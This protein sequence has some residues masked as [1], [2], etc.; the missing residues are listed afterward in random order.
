MLIIASEHRALEIRH[1]GCDVPRKFVLLCVDDELLPLTLR[2]LALEKAGY[3]VIA[4]NSPEEGIIIADNAHTIDLIISD[5]LMPTMSGIQFAKRVKANHPKIPILIFSGVNELP[6][7][8]SPAYGF[9]SKLEGPD[10][11][12]KQIAAVLKQASTAGT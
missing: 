2:K 11:L 1:L 4:A 5:Y 7:D 6:P 12:F 9:V 10:A 3:E 8:L